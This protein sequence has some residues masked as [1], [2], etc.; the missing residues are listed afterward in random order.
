MVD[1]KKVQLVQSFS[2][3]LAKAKSLVLSDYS[4]LS[5]SQQEQLRKQIKEA[6]GEFTVVKNTLLKL[7]L[8]KC[9]LPR[10]L[11]ESESLRGPT[12][13]LLA[14][15]DEIA[16]IKILAQFSQEFEVPQV[17]AGIFEGR[18]IS[19]EAILELA[20]IPGRQEL[21]AQLLWTLGSPITGLA[22]VLEANLRSLVYIL[23]SIKKE[24]GEN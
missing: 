9:G 15:E 11:A 17:K 3:K 5:V 18:P 20:K 2:E 13:T 10:E 12:A 24:G 7:A 14:F 1:P 23:K 19:K 4:G 16:P 21:Q 22:Y 8:E 6:G